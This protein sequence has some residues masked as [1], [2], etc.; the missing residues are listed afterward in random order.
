M[1]PHD[2]LTKLWHGVVV[3]AL[4]AIVVDL[5]TV[6]AWTQQDSK[7]FWQMFDWRVARKKLLGGILT[8]IGTVFGFS[9]AGVNL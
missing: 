2:F 8:G 6:Y 9:L 5:Q 4:P 7:T 3:G 1:T